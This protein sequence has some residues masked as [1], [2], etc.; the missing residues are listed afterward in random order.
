MSKMELDPE[1]KEILQGFVVEGREMLDDAEPLLIELENTSDQSDEVDPE[2]INTIFRLFH[3]L[4]GGAG[5][6]DLDTVQK[7]THHAETLLDMYRKGKAN[8]SGTHIDLLNRTS[9]F[10]RLLLNNIEKNLTDKGFEDNAATIVNDLQRIISSITGDVKDQNSKIADSN[11]QKNVESAASA[12]QNQPA[13]DKTNPPGE[14]QLT[15][16]PEMTKQF[17]TESIELLE[18]A[19]EALLNLENEPD[20][21]EYLSQ[22]FRAL[23]SF[24]GNSGFFGY[25]DLQEVSH[26]AETVLHEIR[27]SKV[28]GDSKIVSLLLEILDFLRA[29]VNQITEGAKPRIIGKIGLINLLKD[30]LKNLGKPQTKPISKPDENKTTSDNANNND[31]QIPADSQANRKANER[32]SGLDRRFSE[33]RRRR[34]RRASDLTTQR[35]S[36]RVDVEKL[37]S[38]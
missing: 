18:S 7:V 10:I 19:E 5:F 37:D 1:E 17:I 2:V 13:S 34:G 12:S 16:T 8:L 26:Q 4:K 35:Q 23:H 14:P 20:N 29:G 11:P 6:L 30:A 24:K 3:S 28:S 9:D 21:E 31:T 38:L 32:R 27:G 33:D 15:I 36:V 22:A 25:S